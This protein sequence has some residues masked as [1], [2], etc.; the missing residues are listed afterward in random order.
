MNGTQLAE[1][2]RIDQTG[3]PNYFVRFL[4]A[5]CAA[6]SFQLY[7]RRLNE[8]LNLRP[9]RRV[10]D[11]GCGTG[12]DARD[13]ALSVGKDGLVVGVDNSQAMVTLAN[14]RA[15]S[16]GLAVEFHVADA[17]KLPFPDGHFDGSRADRSL[18]HV[19]DARGALAE[20]I[21]VTRPGGPIVI[22]EV[23]FETLL[24]DSPH[25]ILTRTIAHTWCDGFRNGWLGRHIPAIVGELGLKDIIVEPYT[26]MLTPE[27]A[28][29]LLGSTTSDRA[30]AAG[31]ITAEQA[32]QWVEHLADLERRG[33]FFSS[34][35]GYLVAG[36]KP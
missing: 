10:L 14:E 1:F 35:S 34:L 8:L 24:L 9:G 19:P 7:K 17:L 20:M 22:Y 6:A 3:D 32:R 11:L 2:G 21:R 26:L 36:R 28:L 5:A 16:S 4:D 30:A 27:L 12:D 31:A 33:C 15:R 13:M 23:D 25:K 18:M 29:P